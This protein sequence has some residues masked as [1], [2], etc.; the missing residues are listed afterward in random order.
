MGGY[1]RGSILILG[2]FSSFSEDVGAELW[3]SRAVKWQR[4]GLCEDRGA[5]AAVGSGTGRTD[6][7]GGE[8]GAPGEEPTSIEPQDPL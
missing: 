3:G 2:A 4:T 1:N 8:A 5:E 7:G 6:W